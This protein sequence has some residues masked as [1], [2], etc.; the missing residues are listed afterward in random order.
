MKNKPTQLKANRSNSVFEEQGRDLTT[1]E[2]NPFEVKV[3]QSVETV[4]DDALSII[5][6]EVS[7]MKRKSTKAKGSGLSTMEVNAL[8]K[9]IRS[10][11]ELSKEMRE[12]QKGEDYTDMSTEQLIEALRRSER[13]IKNKGR[14]ID[15]KKSDSELKDSS[16]EVSGE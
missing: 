7:A 2:S 4:M 13:D 15:I 9:L 10:A 12:R 6:S 3:I 16:D 5:A 11:T 14:V 8:Q 1:T